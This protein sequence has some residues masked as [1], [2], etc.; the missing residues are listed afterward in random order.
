MF[1]AAD[2][3]TA[4]RVIADLRGARLD[5]PTAALVRLQ[6]IRTELAS[7]RADDLLR[8]QAWSAIRRLYDAYKV[9]PDR[10]LKPLWQDAIARTSAWRESLR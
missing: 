1:Y 2:Q 4:E 6:R 7:E 8:T 3:K 5:D 10:D 9:A